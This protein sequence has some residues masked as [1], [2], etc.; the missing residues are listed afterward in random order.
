MT[1]LLRR[2]VTTPAAPEALDV[3][4]RK[5]IDARLFRV[6]AAIRM[7]FFGSGRLL[8]DEMLLRL[9]LMMI[10]GLSML[11]R[12]K[13]PGGDRSDLHCAPMQL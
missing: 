1:E 7:P 6:P 9:D 11:R 3:S 5:Q 2:A 12:K 8:K 10:A 4:H 13:T